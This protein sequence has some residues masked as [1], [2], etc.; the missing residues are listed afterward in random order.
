[1]QTRSKKDFYWLDI[2]NDGSAFCTVT[3]MV[4]HVSPQQRSRNMASVRSF[5]TAPEL[6]V[7]SIL[8]RLGLRFRLQ[9]RSLPG[10]PD[11][12]LKR[13]ATVVFVHG[14]FWHGHN[15]PRGRVPSTRQEFWLPKLKRNR[16]RD[17]ENARQLRLLGWRVL[18]VWEC[19][20]RD[21][22]RLRHK[23]AKAFR[24]KGDGGN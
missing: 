11:I 7:R 9:Q 8:H 4:D 18:N 15:C 10:T 14:C 12:V 19:E 21:E 23:L 6:A 13:Y 1:M 16:E 24:R 5:G 22:L 20:L 17:R 2:D 3:L